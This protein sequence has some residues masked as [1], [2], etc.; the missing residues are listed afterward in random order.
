MYLTDKELHKISG[1][2]ISECNHP[3]HAF[4]SGK[5]IK[6]CSIDIRVSNIFWIPKRQRNSFDLGR[7]NIFEVS[8][9]R[10]WKKIVLSDSESITLKPGQMILGRTYEKISIPNENVGK[11]TTRSSFAR[12]GLWTAGNCDLVNPGYSGHVPLE[13]MNTSPNKIVIHPYLPL[14]QLFVMRLDGEL[15]NSYDSD[16]LDS[17][18]VDDDGGPSVWWRDELVQKISR[19][20]ASNALSKT[21]LE[22]LQKEVHKLDDR[23]LFRLDRFIDSKTF[24]NSDD[25]LSQFAKSERARF[26]LY[27]LRCKIFLWAFPTVLASLVIPELLQPLSKTISLIQD[28]DTSLY[29]RIAATIILGFPA[30]YYFFSKEVHFF[31][32]E[33]DRQQDTD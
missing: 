16:Q 9:R 29:T 22:R 12:L 15:G 11:L 3:D 6:T 17:K 24:S 8:P 19:H 2:V 20:I 14:S 33:N 4:D 18:Y 7:R 25:L 26:R 32:D 30:A 21:V 1:A 13:L 5:Q 27:K 31:L 28:F 23:C 10:M